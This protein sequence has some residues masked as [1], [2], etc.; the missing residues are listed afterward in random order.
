MMRNKVKIGGVGKSP[1]ILKVNNFD[2][3]KYIENYIENKV[4][5]LD[6]KLHCYDD[7]IKILQDYKSVP[8]KF[9]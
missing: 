6:E 3:D 9:K 1:S 7:T 2:I 8:I 4:I 5:I